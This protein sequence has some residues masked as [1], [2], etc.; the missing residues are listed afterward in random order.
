[1]QHNIINME[2]TLDI[3]NLIKPLVDLIVFAEDEISHIFK[4]GIKDY[5]ESHSKKFLS[6]NT[7]LFRYEKISFYKA[8]YPLEV[9]ISRDKYSFESPS[10]IFK[11]EQFIALIGS[12][13][14]GKSTLTKYLFLQSIR[15]EYKIPILV[16]LRQLNNSNNTIEE[17]ITEFLLDV[18]IEQS[19]KYL[20][21]TISKN[22]FLFIFDGFD[23]IYSEN[24]NNILYEI[25][26]FIDKFPNNK[27]IITGRPGSGAEHMPRFNLAKVKPLRRIDVI[28]F[29]Q[30]FVTNIER[31]ERLLTVIRNELNKQY[32]EYLSNPLLLSMFISTFEKYPSIPDLKSEFYSNVFETLY[33]LHDGLI[34]NSYKRQRIS[35]LNKPQILEVLYSFSYSTYLQGLYNF[36]LNLISDTFL[37]IQRCKPFQFEVETLIYDFETSISIWI[38]EGL[39]YKF[40]HRTLQE[41]FV[42]KFISE[43]RNENDK[44]RAYD[45]Y[46]NETLLKSSDSQF[47][48]WELF[49]EL[50]KDGFTKYFIIKYLRSFIKGLRTD[51][52]DYLLISIF[53]K[54][55]IEIQIRLGQEDRIHCYFSGFI[56]PTLLTVLKYLKKEKIL[57]WIIRT[58]EHKPF[59]QELEEYLNSSNK[60]LKLFHPKK[61]KTNATLVNYLRKDKNLKKIVVDYFN[62]THPERIQKT[63]V[64]L[65]R[66]TDLMNDQINYTVRDQ[67]DLINI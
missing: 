48:I 31:R 60:Y 6:T 3:A 25:E 56:S 26:R 28:I 7:F 20:E 27:Y 30:K 5:L 45:R 40:P 10:E 35:K 53:R 17:F 36:K 52:D 33:S 50:D 44:E 61:R 51:S 43:I 11:R 42:V 63:F 46:V 18:K 47:S 57:D 38:K 67:H 4:K 64:E 54:L 58:F 16:E 15:K 34:K 19:E 21:E 1:M 55:K 32:I 13:G 8:Y 29:I 49:M 59:I 65:K 41:Y 22:M 14:S 12:A 62:N 24:R 9:S 23:E 2:P 66:T 37:N 39:E